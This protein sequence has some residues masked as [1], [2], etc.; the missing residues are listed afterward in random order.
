MAAH[1]APPSLGFSRQEHWSGLPFPSP[2]H[3]TEKWSHS[4]VDCRLLHL[5]DFPGKSTGVGCHCLLLT[6]NYVYIKKPEFLPL[7]RHPLTRARRGSC[8]Q[9]SFFPSVLLGLQWGRIPRAH[10]PYKCKG[11]TAQCWLDRW[12]PQVSW[13]DRGELIGMSWGTSGNQHSQD[14]QWLYS[15]SPHKVKYIQMLF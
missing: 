14:F 12:S 15:Q 1:Q 3:E 7:G 5:W 10:K 2:M 9:D 11:S 8:H 6:D 4:V 13:W